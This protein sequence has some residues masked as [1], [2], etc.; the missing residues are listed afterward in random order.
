MDIP[1]RTIGLPDHKVPEM[2]MTGSFEMVPAFLN[3]VVGIGHIVFPG[4]GNVGSFPNLL[5]PT[6][7][8]ST[9]NLMEV[10]KVTLVLY[11]SAQD[12]LF[13]NVIT[14]GIVFGHCL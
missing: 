5:E 12:V 7:L 3:D 10:V 4:V 2:R 8:D 11:N 9:F 13:I 14:D 6:L 1:L